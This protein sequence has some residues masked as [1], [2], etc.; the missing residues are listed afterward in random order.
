MDVSR[1]A[2]RDARWAGVGLYG[3][4]RLAGCPPFAIA[5]RGGGAR[6]TVAPSPCR[7]VSA[8]DAAPEFPGAKKR[9]GP[10]L[11]APLQADASGGT[12]SRDRRYRVQLRHAQDWRDDNARRE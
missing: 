7:S 11:N 5:R 12:L 9:L 6:R 1:R 8:G 4:R 10:L 3:R 2:D